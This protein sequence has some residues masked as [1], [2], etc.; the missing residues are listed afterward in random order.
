MRPL[1]RAIHLDFHTMPGIYD[2]NRGWD[3]AEF[4]R[5]LKEAHVGY[6]N[7]FARCNLGF[8]YYPTKI[9]I[10]YPGMK[11]DMFGDLL[12][13]CHK[14]DI[15]VS[16]Y[17][18]A[19]LD[20][21]HSSRNMGWLRLDREGRVL[22]GD[23]TANFFRTLCYNNPEY[24]A[25]HFGMLK[26][27]SRYDIDGLFLD[28]MNME[29]CYCYHCL[30]KMKSLGID[31]DDAAANVRFQEQSMVEFAEESVNI[32]DPDRKKYIFLNPMH[33]ARVSHLD[34]HIEIECL[35]SVWGYDYFWPYASYARNIKKDVLY[36][37]GRFQFSWGDFGGFK[38]R[39]SLEHDYYDA[40]CAGVGVSVGDHMHPAGNL[41]KEVY[42]V[43]GELN[44]MAA[45]LEHYTEGTRFLA[46]T[47]VVVNRDLVLDPA[48]DNGG[49]LLPDSYSGLARMFG[50]LKQ[51]YDIINE[52]MDFEKYRVLVLPDK[53][54]MNETL[55]S[56][57]ASFLQKGGKVLSSGTAGVDEAQK[58]FALPQWDF[59]FEGLDSSNSSY[60]H[61]INNDDPKVSDMDYCMYSGSGTLIKA[62]RALALYVKAYFDRQWDGFHGYF[63]TPPEKE[64]GHAAAT[65]NRE[66]NVC[67][68]SFEIFNAY[69]NGAAYAA[70][71]L[72]QKCLS[73]LLPDPLIRTEGVPSTARVTATGRG[74]YTLLHVKVTYPE[75]RGRINVIEEHNVLKAGAVVYL[76]GEYESARALPE[77]TP[78]AMA[79]ENGYAKITLPEITGYKMFQLIRKD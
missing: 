75:T 31:P 11:G 12:R 6:I 66:G 58:G 39:E 48:L 14:L 42:K 74:E 41:N 37:T 8:A 50:E 3:P 2:F 78:V 46:D 49:P 64:T 47:G 25:Y 40:L 32:V 19:G 54:R 79:M 36:M 70:K 59:E 33:Y 61:I 60:Y 7:A 28:C 52:D 26:E 63:Y 65:L 56:K 55:R 21:E 29:P 38:N 43:I 35:P 53:L 17:F 71:A 5:T 16:A 24:R 27:I 4:A 69:F 44:E 20:H 45:S 13:E 1:K 68:I 76:K 57:L 18:N 22:R 62:D 9:G 23:R 67:H 73:L 72:V 10:P 15:G 30:T 51:S 34:T 77:K